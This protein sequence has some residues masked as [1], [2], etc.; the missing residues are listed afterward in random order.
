MTIDFG[1]NPGAK[2]SGH[3][4]SQTTTFRYLGF[5][6]ALD[7]FTNNFWRMGS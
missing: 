6:A 7:R 5:E 2:S 4:A 3:R 1:Q